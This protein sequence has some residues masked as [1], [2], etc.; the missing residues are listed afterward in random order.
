MNSL[1]Y[2][3]N[4][5]ER[6]NQINPFKGFNVAFKNNFYRDWI[7][8]DNKFESYNIAYNHFIPIKSSNDMIAARFHAAIAT[9]DVPF[10]GQNVVGQDELNRFDNLNKKKKRRKKS[11]RKI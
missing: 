11:K 9:G 8:S 3:F 10:Q 1:G 4:L 5:D 2:T 7:G 6:D